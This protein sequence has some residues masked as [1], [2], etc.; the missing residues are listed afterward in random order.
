MIE[1]NIPGYKKISLKNLVLDHNGTLACDGI[2]LHGVKQKLIALSEKLSI[3]VLTADTF[4]NVRQQLQDVPCT[5]SILPVEQQDVAK[6]N[7]VQQLGAESCV[8]VGNGRNDCKML[9]AAEMGIVVIQ[10][11]GAASVTVQSADVVCRDIHS[12]FDLLTHPLRLKA[13]LRS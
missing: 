1:V 11:E 2:L 3:H 12:A 4:G 5:L 9:Q 13:T 7:Y 10:E 8:C 6:M